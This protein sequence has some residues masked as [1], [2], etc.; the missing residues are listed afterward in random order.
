[1]NTIQKTVKVCI[2]LMVIGA[3]FGCGYA[4]VN[5]KAQLP[6][7]VRKVY[8]PPFTN[9]TDEPSIGVIMSSALIR[10]IVKSGALVPVAKKDADADLIGTVKSISYYNRIYNADDKA[11]LVTVTVD[12]S[13]KLTKRSGEVVWEV[14]DLVYSDDF[15][16]G[17]STLILDADKELVLEYIAREIAMEF[18]DRLVFGY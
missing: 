2:T 7:D 17:N 8:I 13:V 16:I 14:P 5:T 10:E 15:T 6:A 12:A 11:V 4:I 9:L 3:L 1:M 18:H